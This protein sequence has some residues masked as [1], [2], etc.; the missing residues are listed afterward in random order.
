[1]QG[2]KHA[3]LHVITDLAGSVEGTQ[4]IVDLQPEP[5]DRHHIFEPIWSRSCSKSNYD[6]TTIQFL[7]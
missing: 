2:K 6:G 7:V 4:G 1:M 3:H 5:K